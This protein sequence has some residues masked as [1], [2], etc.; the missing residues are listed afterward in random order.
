MEN[1]LRTD[2]HDV[3]FGNSFE[4]IDQRPQVEVGRRRLHHAHVARAVAVGREA[5][6]QG[7]EVKRGDGVGAVLDALAGAGGGRAAGAQPV[8]VV[9]VALGQG[10]QGL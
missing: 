2:H 9:Q 7:G 3:L 4:Q 6:V 8:D 5:A 1:S 10:L